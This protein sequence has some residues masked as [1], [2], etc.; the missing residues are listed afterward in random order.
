M[1]DPFGK[2][3]NLPTELAYSI[4]ILSKTVNML[5]LTLC[6]IALFTVLL[7]QVCWD[8]FFQFCNI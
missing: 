3:V 7:E 5:D 2:D 8:F 1:V 4:S 6:S